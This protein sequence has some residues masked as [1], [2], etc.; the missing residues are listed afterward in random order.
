MTD[1]TLLRGFSDNTMTFNGAFSAAP[2]RSIILFLSIIIQSVIIAILT[3]HLTKN[4]KK[5]QCI[6]YLF[7]FL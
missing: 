1:N 4:P 3:F 5:N 2:F 6:Y 7:I